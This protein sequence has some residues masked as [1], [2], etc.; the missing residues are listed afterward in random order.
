MRFLKKAM[1]KMKKRKPVM[2]REMPK[3][4]KGKRD[5]EGRYS[6]NAGG[7]VAKAMEVQKPN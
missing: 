3:K 1:G 2:P 5:S 7:L 6:L 4:P